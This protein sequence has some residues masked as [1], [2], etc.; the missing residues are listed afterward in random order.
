MPARDPF[1]VLA[2]LA[3]VFL[4]S[5][6]W[7]VA[8][9]SAQHADPLT[10]LSVRFASAAMI[11]ALFAWWAGAQW[12]QTR[13]AWVHGLVSGM[14]LH[15]LYLGAVWWAVRQ[16]LP[17][18][19]SGVIA[20]LQPILTAAFAPFVLGERLTGW[21]A[22]GVGIGF[23]GIVLVL[24]PKLSGLPVEHLSLVLLPIAV[25]IAGMVAVTLGTFY[26]KAKLRTGDL[27][28]LTAVQYLGAVLVVLP[29]AAV[30]E[31]M[32]I[33][34]N[35]TMFAVLAWSVLAL[36]VGAIGL[37]LLLIRRGD[38]TRAATYIYLVPAVTALQA[39]AF[40]GE[41]LMPIQILGMAI[42]VIGVVLASG[43]SGLRK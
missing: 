12:P 32:Q 28:T 42:T 26:Q 24:A 22:L 37:L 41:T 9:F 29:A 38:V 11:V 35:L 25:N 15:G 10:F 2:P 18:G 33:T 31:P 1:L 8:G 23:A 30:L 21:R 16:G 34:W 7:I 4:W 43:M 40:L 36:S 17:A 14:L 27:R 20:A 13:A 6:G 19:L 3:F 39:W 5:T